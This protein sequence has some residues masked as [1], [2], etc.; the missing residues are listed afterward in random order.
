MRIQTMVKFSAEKPMKFR[1]FIVLSPCMLVW[2]AALSA[3]TPATKPEPSP[4]SGMERL[5][6]NLSGTWTAQE[7]YDPGRL[8]PKGG[9]S[10]SRY[11]YRI[12]P[13]R[14]SLIEEYQSDGAAGK[15]W[16]IGIIWLD[17]KTRTF[18]VTWC[19]S[20]ALDEGC[21]TSPQVGK[22]NSDAFEISDA[23]EVDGK[24]VFE[25]EVWSN[26]TPTSYI[27]TLFTG[28]SPQTLKRFLTIKSTR[29]AS[30]N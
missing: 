28:D 29:V 5:I 17:R 30:G 23:H 26:F 21:R 14:L 2:L 20:F 24:M 4:E 12:G 10:H 13:G 15:S 9:I 1:R 16:G 11:A 27:Q 7:I 19:D 3:Q 22:W 25:K 8:M 18:G 6:R